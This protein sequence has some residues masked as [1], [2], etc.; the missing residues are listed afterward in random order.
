MLVL[1]QVDI[2]KAYFLEAK[3]NTPFLNVGRNLME[4]YLSHTQAPTQSS[5][6]I[7]AAC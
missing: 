2:R 1:T 4:I 5:Q 3:L 7:L 6:R